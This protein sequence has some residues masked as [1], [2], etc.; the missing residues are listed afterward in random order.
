[1]VT[2]D[3]RR[4]GKEYRRHRDAPGENATAR[5]DDE[6]LNYVCVCGREVGEGEK[7]GGALGLGCP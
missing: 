1:M 3:A 4:K 2:S 5:Y 6:V 7:L